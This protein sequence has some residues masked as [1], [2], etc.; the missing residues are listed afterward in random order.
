MVFKYIYSSGNFLNYINLIKW[1]QSS[2]N[3][4]IC[5]PGPQNHDKGQFF[6]I[7]IYTSSE[8]WIIKL[9]IDAWLLG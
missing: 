7:E 3:D 2:P 1:C 9:S 6:E 8:R 4:Q 5:D